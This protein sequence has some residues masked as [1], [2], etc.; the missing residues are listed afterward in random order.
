V[1]LLAERSEVMAACYEGNKQT[2]RVERLTHLSLHRVSQNICTTLLCYTATRSMLVHLIVR[3]TMATVLQ[4]TVQSERREGSSAWILCLS[5]LQCANLVCASLV[6]AKL[7]NATVS[8]SPITKCSRKTQFCATALT[9]GQEV[10]RGPWVLW[11]AESRA[12]TSQVDWLLALSTCGFLVAIDSAINC[13][14]WLYHVEQANHAHSLSSRWASKPR[15]FPV[16]MLSKQTTHIPCHHVEQANHAHSLSSHTRSNQLT[17]C[18]FLILCIEPAFCILFPIIV[19]QSAQIAGLR[20]QSHGII[21][22]P[23]FRIFC[24]SIEHYRNIC[25]VSWTATYV[26]SALVAM[27]R[28]SAGHRLNT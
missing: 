1:L 9:R 24:Q 14:T 27:L 10:C 13:K 26:I 21:A 20:T 28:C 16:I 19:S 15:T 8:L 4:S 17:L 12:L 23:T 11:K 18:V 5:L 22:A 2:E 7:F 3:S 6:C 25:T